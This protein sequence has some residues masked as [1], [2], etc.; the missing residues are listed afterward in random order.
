MT[1]MDQDENFK[2]FGWVT[3]AVCVP[4]YLGILLI[5]NLDALAPL[6]RRVIA[7]WHKF[8]GK[9][10]MP[11]HGSGL[12]KTR[13]RKKLKPIQNTALNSNL[14]RRL[15]SMSSETGIQPI[16]RR[17]SHELREMGA[18]GGISAMPPRRSTVT[19][20]EPFIRPVRRVGEVV[21]E[22]SPNTSEMD[23]PGRVRRPDRVR[24][25]P[26]GRQGRRESAPGRMA[27]LRRFSSGSGS[28]RERAGLSP[29]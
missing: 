2:R 15:T 25:A 24:T 4:A 8:R 22:P 5:S 19:F 21:A 13:D 12:Y 23:V 20:S 16:D 10:P 18:N 14:K 27:L 29:V 3:V 26:E 11:K 7:R 9:D 17:A 6:R 28:G 1:N